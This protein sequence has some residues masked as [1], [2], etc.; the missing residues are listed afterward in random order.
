MCT[1]IKVYGLGMN[2]DKLI[3]EI[4]GSDKNRANPI[5]ESVIMTFVLYHLSC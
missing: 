3:F 4:Y 2:I 5:F 1:G